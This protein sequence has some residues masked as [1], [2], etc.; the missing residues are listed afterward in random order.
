MQGNRGKIRHWYQHVPTAS[1]TS[2]EDTITI[3]WNQQVHTDR[4][5]H[6]NRPDI[7]I[8]DNEKGTSMLI[9]VEILGDKNVIKNEAEKIL[10]FEDLTKTNTAHVGM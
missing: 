2:Q 6:N 1:E 7:I 10:K 9:A 4:N 8:S 3:F 5:I